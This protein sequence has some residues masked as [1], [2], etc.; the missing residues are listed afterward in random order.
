MMPIF[1]FFTVDRALRRA[2]LRRRSRHKL[3]SRD[4]ARDPPTN[5][6]LRAVFLVPRAGALTREFF[7]LSLAA[8][9]DA[10][11]A[12]SRV[13]QSLPPSPSPGFPRSHRAID[14]APTSD[15]SPAIGSP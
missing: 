7:S 12:L 11:G 15:S 4:G 10:F 6:F 13:K 2:M 3:T 1:S 14:P 9:A 5:P 8:V